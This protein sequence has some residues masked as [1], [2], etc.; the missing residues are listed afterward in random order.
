MSANQK[1]AQA[2][3]GGTYTGSV[4]G[5][6]ISVVVNATMNGIRAQTIGQ[7]SVGVLIPTG[8]DHRF[9]AS[10]ECVAVAGVP[11]YVLCLCFVCMVVRRV[12]VLVSVEWGRCAV[13]DVVAY[14]RSHLVSS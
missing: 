11:V 6:N 5:I 1:S 4:K 7:A 10:V 3:Y 9:F 13:A 2:R 14:P 8:V 12:H